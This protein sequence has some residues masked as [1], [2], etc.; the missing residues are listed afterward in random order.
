[1][2]DITLVAIEFQWHDLTKY[3]ISRS[4]DNIDPKEV[5]IISDREI[6]PGARHIIRPPVKNIAEYA[7]IML[8]GV[9]EHVNTEHALYVQWDGIANRKDLW[10]DDFLKYDYIGAPWP[11][12]PEGQNV[13][14]GGFS[15]RSK[16]LLEICATDSNIQLTKEEPVAEDNVI[17]QH[18]RSYLESKGI[19]FASIDIAEQ[20][21]FELGKKRDSFG[22]HGLWNVF[23]YMDEVDV[24]YFMPRIDYKGW[25]VY[26][27]H[28]VLRAIIDS[29]RQDVYTYVL[30]QL[31]N[32][33][34]ELLQ[35]VA[36]WLEREGTNEQN[37]II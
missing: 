6:L 1:M 4:L 32:N 11:W 36:D 9:N 33:S 15:L 5:L 18:K 29:N 30:D 7:R 27:W 21:S 8:K 26:K 10:T 28:H 16:R 22:F 34:P 12:K 23:A 24:D 17:G 3:A 35:P 20:F 31:I 2:K 13:G 25:N 14:N 19:K 37:L